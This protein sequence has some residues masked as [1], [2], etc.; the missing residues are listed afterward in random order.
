MAQVTVLS[1]VLQLLPRDS[2]NR[3]VKKRQSNKHSKGISTWDHLVSMLYGHIADAQSVRDISNGLR[4]TLG[5]RNHL[6]VGRVPCK[7]S[8]SYLNKHRGWQVFRDYY[9]E[10]YDQLR[11]QGLPRRAHLKNIRRNILLM[12]A[13]VI[14][15][16]LSLYDWAQYRS[17]KGGIKLHAV[18]DYDGLLP[19]F[20][21]LTDAKTHEVTVAREQVYPKGS[22]LVFDRGYTDFS[23][24]NVLDST[25]V[26]FITRAKNNLDYRIVKEHPIRPKDQGEVLGDYTVEVGS[27]RAKQAGLKHLRLIRYYDNEQDRIF[28]FVTNQTSWTAADVALAYKERWHIEVF[29]KFIKQNLHIKSFVGTSPNAVLTQV[30]TGLIAF[31]LL[32]YLQHKA[33]FKWALSNLANFIRLACFTKVPLMQWLDHP[34]EVEKPPPKDGILTLF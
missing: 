30:W 13:S 7:S 14:P 16:C 2:F 19:V 33:A 27:P 5:D 8:L 1:Q 24:W 31:L 17:K 10:L 18:L 15:L 21:D 29:F 12:D 22:V 3:V 26:F 23:W 34:F 20:C 32:K 11:V 6:G 28:E 25:G 9:F 4:S